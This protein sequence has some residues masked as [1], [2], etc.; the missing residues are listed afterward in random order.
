[1]IEIIH[2]SIIYDDYSRFYDIYLCINKP[3]FWCILII[4][5]FLLFFTGNNNVLGR[6][7]PI[8]V[9]LNKPLFC[10]YRL[11]HSFYNNVLGGNTRYRARLNKPL[12]CGYR[13]FHSFYN[14]VLGGNVIDYVGIVMPRYINII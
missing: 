14:N 13:L 8:R 9:S 3:L 12:F 5:L 1:H 7:L 6:N 11:F 4:P 2:F 10:G